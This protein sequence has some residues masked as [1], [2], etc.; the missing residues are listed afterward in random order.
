MLLMIWSMMS[1]RAWRVGAVSTFAVW[2][3]L[4]RNQM[5][6]RLILERPSAMRRCWSSSSRAL[7]SRD[8]FSSAHTS[9]EVV[10]IVG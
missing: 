1:S 3:I 10:V 6:G 5:T 8:S 9:L 2:G 7:L 4:I